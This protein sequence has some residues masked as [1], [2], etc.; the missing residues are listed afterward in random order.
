MTPEVEEDILDVV[1]E[2]PGI[3]GSRSFDCLESVVRTTV[4][5]PSAVCTGLVSTRLHHVSN[6]LL[7][8]LTALAFVI[9]TVEAEFTRDGIQNFHNQHLWA[10]GNPHAILPSHH[11]Q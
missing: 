1:N 8:V 7:M 4:S 3:R 11:Q 5:I 9:F 10:D 2:T 6:I